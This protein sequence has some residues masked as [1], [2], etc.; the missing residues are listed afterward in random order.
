L[1]GSA[2]IHQYIGKNRSA[3][4]ADASGMALLGT[5]IHSTTLT[6]CCC[7]TVSSRLYDH[8][9]IGVAYLLANSTSH[10]QSWSCSMAGVSP[11]LGLQA[12]AVALCTATPEMLTRSSASR[13][14]TTWLDMQSSTMTGLRLEAQATAAATTATAQKAAGT[15]ILAVPP[16]TGTVIQWAPFLSRYLKG[17]G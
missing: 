11:I 10:K 7:A 1:V 17:S 9:A 12:L 3:E 6:A 16:G 5:S 13:A 14:S 4:Q 2:D 15:A 8:D